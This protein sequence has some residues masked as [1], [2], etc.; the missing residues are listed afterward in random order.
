MDHLDNKLRASGCAALLGFALLISCVPQAAAQ[1]PDGNAAVQQAR[2]FN[3]RPTSEVSATGEQLFRPLDE[4][5][6]SGES[7]ADRDLGEQWLL[8]RNLPTNP[9]TV[10]ASFSI[11]YTDNVALSRRG[12]LSDAFGVADLGIGYTRPFAGDWTFAIN[13]QQTF[14]RYHKYHEFDFESSAANVAISRPFP[15]FGN[16]LLS[17]QYSLSRLT[18]GSLDDQIYFGHTFALVA[19][20]VIQINPANT[21]DFSGSAGYTFADPSDLQRAELRAA[22]GYTVQISRKFSA[23]AAARLEFY[24]YTND[25]REDLLQSVALGARWDVTDWMF[26]SASFSV[27]NNLSSQ[28]V[29]SYRAINTGATVAAHIRF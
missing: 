16:I 11:L 15:Q 23:T 22:I 14:F 5:T 8:R 27:A 24:G 6:G 13:L 7:A 21:V 2:L 9:F 20:K 4:T 28:P 12:T 26:V 18:G 3:E 25:D 1:T 17:L 10:R 19:T 29:F